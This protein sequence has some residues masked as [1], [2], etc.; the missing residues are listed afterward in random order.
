MSEQQ[1]RPGKYP[2]EMRERAV[3]LVLEHQDEY[4]VSVGGDLLGR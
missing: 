1:R 4:G 3:R 2:V